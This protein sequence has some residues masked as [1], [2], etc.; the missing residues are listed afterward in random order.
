MRVQP[1]TSQKAE[2]IE[3]IKQA[4]EEMK[5]IKEGKLEGFPANELLKELPS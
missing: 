5:L 3:S 4:V 1:L 2:M